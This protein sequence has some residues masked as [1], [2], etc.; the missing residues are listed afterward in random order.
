LG[1]RRRART[2]PA[3][4]SGGCR[5]RRTFRIWPGLHVSA[6][7]SQE[8]RHICRFSPRR[9]FV[10]TIG[11]VPYPLPPCFRFASLFFEP[12]SLPFPVPV[13]FFLPPFFSG[14]PPAHRGTWHLLIF[15]A[16]ISGKSP[17]CLRACCFVNF[18][19]TTTSIE[20]QAPPATLI[21]M[22]QPFE[23]PLFVY[24][25][26]CRHI[27]HRYSLPH[28]SRKLGANH[29]RHAGYLE[30]H[31][32]ISCFVLYV[33]QIGCASSTLDQLLHGP[34]RHSTIFALFIFHV[35]CCDERAID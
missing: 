12:G 31:R 25:A 30:Y 32:P 22:A 17:D 9:Y 10:S 29:A 33:D 11:D 27:I 34:S 26:Q 14:E 2:W 28:T 20:F 5:P 3:F 8:R 16:A 24:C 35:L 15:G 13:Y 1:A 18:A 23:T 19:D 7:C 6:N 21:L 4:P